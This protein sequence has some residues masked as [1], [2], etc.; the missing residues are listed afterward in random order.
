MLNYIRNL[1][2]LGLLLQQ[3]KNFRNIYKCKFR[4]KLI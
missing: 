4:L 1:I 3:I 2:D